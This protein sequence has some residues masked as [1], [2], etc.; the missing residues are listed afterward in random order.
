MYIHTHIHRYIYIYKTPISSITI[1]KAS[2]AKSSLRVV[3]SCM[4]LVILFAAASGSLP[5]NRTLYVKSD[6]LA[7]VSLAQL[8]E[9]ALPKRMVVGS[10][11]HT[12]LVI[13]SES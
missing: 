9:H 6:I 1:P 3:N 4:V 8:A 7:C 12:S 10:I 13:T 2:R 11:P 5:T